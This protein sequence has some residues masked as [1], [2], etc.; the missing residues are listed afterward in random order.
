[1]RRIRQHL[2][3]ANVASA[4]ALFVAVSG[5]TAVALTGSNTVQTDDIGPGAQ[6]QAADVA[7][8]AVN[9]SDV[10]DNALAGADINESSLTGNTKKLV[11][12]SAASG[13][14]SPTPIATVG[15]YTIKAKCVGNGIDVKAFL[16][17]NGPAGS[18][19]SMWGLTRNDN[20]DLGTRS[21]T[22]S[23]AANADS[24]IGQVASGPSSGDFSR[25]S[26]TQ[27]LRSG[28]TL[29]EVNFHGVADDGANTCRFYGA[30]TV[31]T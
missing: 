25:I 28:S 6:V 3:F 8:N 4:I 26:G 1:M 31:G 21:L 22:W 2:S 20:T 12:T 16:F 15:P 9:G 5:G 30:A 7:A 23:I 17:A 29:V 14:P 27:M 18:S 24:T 13:N 19:D 10:V 11:W